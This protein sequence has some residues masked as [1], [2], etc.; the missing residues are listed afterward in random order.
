MKAA[1]G[2]LV[3]GAMFLFACEANERSPD[4]VT[5]LYVR[6]ELGEYESAL[7][8][9]TSGDVW[10]VKGTTDAYRKLVAAYRAKSASLSVYGELY[11]EAQGV[12]DSS[13]GAQEPN[14]HYKGVFH[15][16]KLIRYSTDAKII[17]N[18]RGKIEQAAP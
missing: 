4:I 3:I 1:A 2:A 5:G 8:R 15:I 9:C 7:I 10:F 14:S 13:D 6:Y 17:S 11:I 18:C 16:D 12:L